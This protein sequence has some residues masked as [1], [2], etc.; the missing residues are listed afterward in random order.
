[1]KP[2]DRALCEVEI[3]LEPESD[4]VQVNVYEVGGDY[5][6]AFVP[7]SA[8]HEQPAPTSAA[9]GRIGVGVYEPAMDAAIKAADEAMLLVVLYGAQPSLVARTAVT[10]YLCALPADNPE[11]EGWLTSEIAGCSAD[12]CPASSAAYPRTH[13]SRATADSR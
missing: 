6:T 9:D 4:G 3:D 5:V 1:M 8:V 10:A 12:T 13:C 2:G 11:A 7:L